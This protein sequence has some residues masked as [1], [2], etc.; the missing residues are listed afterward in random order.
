[1]FVR[2]LVGERFAV[3]NSGA[4]AVV[5]GVGDHG[6]EYMTGG[7]VVVLGAVGRNFA[8]G[9][10]GG[11]AYVLDLHRSRV[12]AEMVDLE[13][14][15]E[16]D[17]DLLHHLVDRHTEL[18]GSAVGAALLRDW[19]AAAARFTK[20]MPRDYKNVLDARASALEA[21]FDEDSPETLTA[22]MEASRG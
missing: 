4:T 3:R 10:S 7:Q 9:M 22:I 21:G 16:E 5:E 19:R 2:G 6:C 13:D 11:T 8:A 18:T 12:N 1:V 14:L 17:V 20:V 15:D